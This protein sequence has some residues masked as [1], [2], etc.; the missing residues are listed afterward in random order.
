[1]AR[2]L[3]KILTVSIL[4]LAA[5]VC[6]SQPIIAP[7]KTA[8]HNLQIDTR[9]NHFSGM[10]IARPT[11]EGPRVLATSYFGPTI[12]DF[13]LTPDSL[14]VNSCVE[15]MRRP[16]VQQLLERD[17]RVVLTD[18]NLAK[19]KK[20]TDYIEQRKRGHGFGKSAFTTI[21]NADGSVSRVLIK[22]PWIRLE[23]TIEEIK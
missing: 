18:R 15:P 3:L 10:M 22:H 14:K 23:L 17:L 2:Q 20:K 19:L 5:N 16:K 8:R 21:Y 6:F 9:G 12:F 4:L 1:M 13:T 7:G 11:A